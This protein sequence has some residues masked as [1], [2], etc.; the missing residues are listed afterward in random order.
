[1]VA[2]YG[3]AVDPTLVPANVQ[4]ALAEQ[5]QRSQA[6][7]LTDFLNRQFSSVSINHAQ[8]NPL[9]PD[10]NFRGFTASPLLGLPQGLSVYENGVRI[11]DPFGDTINWDLIPVSAID[12]VQMLAGA[13]PVFG[14]NTLGGALSLRMKNG[15]GQQG[16]QLDA[17]GGAFGRLGTS[18]QV[19][20]NDGR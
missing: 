16:T 2:P 5:L 9:Q 6:L 11:N 14:L 12:N 3:T 8:N 10:F 19:G 15:F 1:V 20:G 7:D 13:Q 18:L 4:R 17:Y